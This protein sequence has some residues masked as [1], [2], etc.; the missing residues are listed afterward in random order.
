VSVTRLFGQLSP[1]DLS[2]PHEK[3]EGI[4]NCT[5]CHVLGNKVSGEKCLACHTEIQSRIA[6]QKGYHSSAEVRGKECY[7]CHSEHNG[8][9]FQ[10][11]RLDTAKFDHNLTGFNLSVPHDKKGCRDCHTAKF[12]S[13]PK[14]KNNKTTYLGVK[15]DCLN[16]HADYHKSTLSPDCL[17]C[18]NPAAFKPAAKFNHN[19]AKFRLLGKHTSV[20]CIKCHKVETLERKKYQEF[21]GL[22]FS[23]CTSCHKDPHKNQFGQNCRQCH[24][25]ESFQVV[26]G[27]NNFDHSKTAFKLEEKHLTVSCKSCHKNKLTDPLKFAKC[28]DCH[29]D[30]HKSQFAK[31]GVSPDCAQCHTVKGFN[32]FSYTIEQHNNAVFTLKGSHLAVPCTDCHKKQETWNF[33]NIGSKC[34]DCHKDIHQQYIQAKFYP[35]ANCLIC[36]KEEKWS[37]VAFN[38]TGTS[39]ALTGAHVGLNCRKCHFKDVS[40]TVTQQKFTGLSAECSSCHTDNHYKQFEK[41]GV[42]DCSRC[43][44]AT[45]WKLTKFDH[46]TAAFKLDGKHINVPCSK[47]HK[48]Q[49]EGSVIYTKYKLKEYKCESCHF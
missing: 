9:N 36:H 18:H 25:E 24:S 7:A 11:I 45:N 31:N 32:Q 21:K 1:G 38:H 40:S 17:I 26:K 5:Q 42:T 49:Q 35:E 12:I 27:G 3:L 14:L 39:F 43:H 23:N 19:N 37:D 34:K 22:Q 41:N 48:P 10:L 33:R 30:Y 47:C 4:S 8:K 20:D 29:I 15:T 2:K 28:T 16:C 13:E 44:V 6:N 46:N